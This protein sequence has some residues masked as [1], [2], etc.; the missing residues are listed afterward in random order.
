MILAV[1]PGLGNI[2][3]AVV[4]RGTARVIDVGLLQ[5]E[6]DRAIAKSTDRARRIA[7]ATTELKCI[8]EQHQCDT[9]AAESML[10]HGAAAA[11]A[12]NLLPWGALVALSVCIGV[13]LVE[14]TAKR[15]QHAVLG[16][17]KGKVDYGALAKCLERFA[18]N[19]LGPRLQQIP[20]NKH[21]HVL[22]AI[23]V[24]LY[25]ALTRAHAVRV[26]RPEATA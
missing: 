24:G 19:Q 7:R 18:A 4:R 3:W 11:I 20:K 9:I 10:A 12:A 16:I 13:D 14:V 15:W 23:G 5:S 22:D 6:P 17:D 26:Y 2:G 21:T 8:A 25:A 1:D